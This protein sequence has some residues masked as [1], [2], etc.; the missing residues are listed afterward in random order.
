MSTRK[1]RGDS[2]LDALLPEQQE[3]LAEWLTI[4]NLTYA[5][6]KERVQ[7]EFGVSTTPSALQGF[8]SR[9]AAPWKYARARGEAESFAALLEGKFD[10]AS[11]K[12]VQ[13]LAFEAL[14]SPSPDTKAAKTFFKILG[15]TA[16]VEIARDRVTLDARKV[17]LLEQKAA[18]AEAAE[19]V[20]KDATLTPEAR[21]A[22]LKEIFGLR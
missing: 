18:Q 6:A 16:K 22:K 14:N 2:K 4:E 5:E 1:P 10:E 15:D 7:A 21:E 19:N 13:Q 20:T 3:R 8:Y 17:K 9:F 11:K 12:K